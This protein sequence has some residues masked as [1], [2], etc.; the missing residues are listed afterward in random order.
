MNYLKNNALL[1]LILVAVLYG[2]FGGSS[3]PLFG[4][5]VNEDTTI[6]SRV[7]FENRV[8]A[9]GLTLGGDLCTLTDA[10]G[11]AYALTEAQMLACNV[12]EFAAGGAGQEVIAL[13]FPA[14]STMT[15][16]IPNAGDCRF[17]WYDASALAAATTTTLTAGTGHN[18]IAYTT[19]D[20][21][22]DGL[23]FSQWTM[24]RAADTDVNTFV[25]E[26]LHA[27]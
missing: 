14:T 18:V 5:A 22:I 13:S 16:L 20:D 27:D 15:T 6:S 17:W 9:Q 1:L 8:S 4:A 19:D 26:M 2:A 25:S 11:G 12:F 24:C 3:V 10:N 23:E 7:T 21:V